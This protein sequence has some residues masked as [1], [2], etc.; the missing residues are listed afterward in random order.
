MSKY[1]GSFIGLAV[2][3]ALGMVVEFEQPGGFESVT[4]MRAGGPFDLPKGYWTDDTSMALCL[5]DSLLECDG[6][7]SY[8]VMGR[9]WRWRTE[10]YRSSI[11]SCFDIG[12]QTMS[13]LNEFYQ[14]NG[15]W[16][17]KDRARSE[18][19]GNGP[20]MRLAPIVIAS[21]AG[22]N[23]LEKTMRLSAISARETHYSHEAEQ[24]TALF[25]AWLYRAFTA[26]KKFE[27][28]DY[29][30]YKNSEFLSVVMK[31]GMGDLPENQLDSGGY[32]VSSMQVALWGFMQHDSFEEGMLAVT[33][34]G[35]D[36][37]T[38]AA[39]Y[40]QLAGAYYGY[41]AIPERWRK[42]LFKESEIREL[43]DRLAAMGSLRVLSTRFEED[44]GR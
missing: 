3:D 27:I 15:G 10:G 22:G 33:N 1:R 43:A 25:A 5:A 39:I 21:H 2:G 8:D 18:S 20:I 38:N 7:D 4:D 29:G 19:A 14:D 24:G 40:G 17:S 42:D 36:A 32:I 23:S 37:D 28:F 26:Q 34:L 44:E 31:V 16:V 30:E 11:G 12:N 13:A 9:Y 6:Y 41:E 35:G